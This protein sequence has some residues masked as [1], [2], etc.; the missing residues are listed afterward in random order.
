MKYS[1]EFSL[2]KWICTSMKWVVVMMGFS[3]TVAQATPYTYAFNIG[4]DHSDSTAFF[5][6]SAV[7]EVTVDNG[8]NSNTTQNYTWS[9]ISYLNLYTQGG[10]YGLATVYPSGYPA[11]L[12]SISS[13][14]NTDHA[15]LF[16]TDPSGAH[17]SWAGTSQT[18]QFDQYK[19]LYRESY[20]VEV[21]AGAI[22]GLTLYYA[23]YA[24]YCQQGPCFT[25]TA[26]TQ[27]L[28]AGLS[29]ALIANPPYLQVI[30]LPGSWIML[31]SGLLMIGIRGKKNQPGLLNV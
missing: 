7:L 24:P 18:E 5:G 12:A 10:Y 3:S 22:H 31:A 16:N 17:A 8:S 13:S 6:S 9:D 1:N 2:K 27:T 4:Y 15:A 29:G 28:N 11:T 20:Y 25:E 21:G 23:Y 19:S 14:H 30:P 26:Y